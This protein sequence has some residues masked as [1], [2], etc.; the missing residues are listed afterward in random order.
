MG[1]DVY[2]WALS[3]SG[4]RER[5]CRDQPRSEWNPWSSSRT[6]VARW[7]SLFSRPEMEVFDASENGC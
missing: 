3:I 5:T 2:E 7:G 6:R 1:L 4:A